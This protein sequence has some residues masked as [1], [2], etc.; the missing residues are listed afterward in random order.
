MRAGPLAILIPIDQP[1][2]RPEPAN[3]NE[4]DDGHQNQ[5]RSKANSQGILPF[6][7]EL[8]RLDSSSNRGYHG[9]SFFPLIPLP[10]LS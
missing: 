10:F 8:N 7:R 9:L 1:T 4:G 2:D 6:R 3:E 5:E